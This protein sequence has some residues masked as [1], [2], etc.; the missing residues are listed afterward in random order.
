MSKSIR[1]K[2]FIELRREFPTFSYEK[3]DYLLTES[4]LEVRYTFSISER[5]HFHHTLFFPRKSWFLPDENILP[6]LPNILFQIGMI[7]LI[8]YWKLT[9]SPQL[10]IKPHRLLPEQ[11][12]WWKKLYFNGL[13]EFIYLNSLETVMDDFM[14]FEVASDDLLPLTN[15]GV[16][17]S[18]LIPVGGGKDSV[19]TL[20]ILRHHISCL[21]FIL[22]PRGASLETIQASGFRREG[23]VEAIRT[24]DPLLIKLNG[25]GFLNGHVPFSAVLAFTGVLAAILSG[26]QYIALSNESSANEATVENTTINHQYSKSVEFELDF[27]SYLAKYITPG[28][29]YFSFLRPLS[30]IQIARLFAKYPAHHAV[31]RSCNAGSKTDSWCGKCA[32]CLFTF[33]ILSP[34]F[35]AAKLVTIFGSNLLDD[36][37]L[38]PLFDQLIGTVPEKP[39][40]CVG[41]MEE[42]NL[43]LGKV[44]RQSNAGRLPALLSY[45]S[46]LPLFRRFSE[47]KFGEALSSF[48]QEN[49]LPPVFEHQ[50]RSVLY[51]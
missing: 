34:F 11:V 39:F 2:K 5:F 36:V 46:S 29:N 41:T 4:G 40:D 26:R 47:E 23:L 17:P 9:C 31:F 16:S 10:I 43:A 15:P 27:R 24:L 38:K 44:I 49:F 30:E 22:N 37:E 1:Q 18:A 45:Y 3:Y 12:S 42:V 28:I 32:K 19:V 35:P 33:I 21:P 51:A 48:N 25:E 50:L 20:E 14:L 6:H 8:S 7:E 13:G